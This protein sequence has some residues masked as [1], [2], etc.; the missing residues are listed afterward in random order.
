LTA[1]LRRK[2]AAGIFDHWLK[3]AELGHEWLRVGVATAPADRDAAEHILTDMYNRHRRARPRFVWV[4]SPRPGL[5]LAA[6]IPNHEDLRAWL[7]PRQPSGRPP[8]AVDIAARWSRMMANLDEGATHPDL[9]LPKLARKRDKPWPVLPP[10]QAL[11]AGVPLRLVLRQ[12]IRDALRTVLMDSIALRVR[13]A[14]GPTAQTPICWY[15]QQDAYWIAHYDILRRLGL[16]DYPPGP[17]ADLDAWAT[18]ARTAGWWWPGEQVCVMVERPARIDPVQL[19]PEA[20]EVRTEPAV[21]Y[22]DGWSPR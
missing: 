15:G 18:L 6:G 1:T 14:L 7:R 13:A 19:H 8:L 11:E 4:E 21:V 16:A 5:A 12:T 2:V 9:A 20:I 17:A 22:R 3:A 10:E